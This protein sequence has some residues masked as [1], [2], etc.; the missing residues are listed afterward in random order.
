MNVR[1]GK[2]C[3]DLVGTKVRTQCL[4]H[5]LDIWSLHDFAGKRY[6]KCGMW[7][8]YTKI[9]TKN[10]QLQRE[11]HLPGPTLLGG[12]LQSEGPNMSKEQWE[13]CLV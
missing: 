8:N 1:C 9:A 7:G 13:Y 3:G 4:K 6:P 11:N 2:S 5:I 12:D 10:G